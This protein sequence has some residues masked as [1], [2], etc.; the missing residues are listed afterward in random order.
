MD[1]ADHGHRRAILE[2][3][4]P[5]DGVIECGSSAAAPP[6]VFGGVVALARS[7]MP[8]EALPLRL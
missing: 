6:R 8:N 7:R 2:F 4:I 1:Q 5:G 3:E